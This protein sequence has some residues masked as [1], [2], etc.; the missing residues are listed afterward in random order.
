MKELYDMEVEQAE[1]LLRERGRDPADFT[2]EREFLQPDFDGGGMF[3]VQYAVLITHKPS[4]RTMEPIGG[5]GMDWL[6]VFADKLDS[7]HFD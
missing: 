6:G 3:T 7:G 5:I 1:G 2:F 4:G